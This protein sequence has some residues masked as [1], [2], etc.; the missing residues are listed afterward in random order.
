MPHKHLAATVPEDMAGRRLDQVL[1]ELFPQYSR[2]RLQ[3]WLRD[4]LIKVDS[5]TPRARDKVGGGERIE[6][7][8]AVT[9][10]APWEGEPIPLAVIHEDEALIVVDKPCGLVVHPAV[11]NRSGTLVNALL[12]YAPEL[13]G[14]PRAGIVHRL[15]KDTSG[16]MVVARSLEAHAFLVDQIQRRLVSR[17]YVALVYGELTGGGRIDQPV[18]RHPVH[19][20]RM[21]VTPTGKQAAT[22]YRVEERLRGFTLVRA[23][24]ESGRTHQIRVHMSHLNHPLVGDPVYGRLRIPR[25]AGPELIEALRGFRRQALHAERLALMHPVTGRSVQWRAP[26]PADMLAL[27]QVL[28][29]AAPGPSTPS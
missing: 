20:Q 19:R 3:Q 24:L 6:V 1:A 13:A 28:R 4:G 18:G 16:L 21:A 7:T 27:L 5:A 11:G 10:E 2:S 8:A 25:G 23:L 12:H 29:T 22:R 26:Q 9:E 17:E 14:V 15:D